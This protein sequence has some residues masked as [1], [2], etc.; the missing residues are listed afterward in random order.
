MRNISRISAPAGS[1][2]A[3]AALALALLVGASPARAATLS[4]SELIE[5]DLVITEVMADPSKVDDSRG[6]YFEIYNAAGDDVDLNGLELSDDGVDTYTISSSVVV[7]AGEKIVLG[8]NSD[9]TL[10]GGIPVVDAVYTRSKFRFDNAAD[11]IYL[12]YG[13]T[14][15]DSFKWG[16]TTGF[17]ASTSGVAFNLDVGHIDGEKNDRAYYWCDAS[18]PYGSGDLGTPGDDNDDC[19]ITAAGVSEL[20]RGDL[21]LTEV[22]IDPTKVDD[23]VGEWFEIYN[24]SGMEVNLYGLVL[25]D[26]G[27]DVYTLASDFIAEPGDYVL[28][29]VKSSTSVNGGL[30]TVD[31]TWVRSTFRFDNPADEIVINSG[32]EDLDEMSWTRST[33]LTSGS[34]WSL[35]PESM[36][37]DANDSSSA[38]CAGATSYGLGDLGTPGSANDDC[39]EDLDG[40]GYAGAE[41]CDDG[42]A[43]INPGATETCNDLDDN[44]DDLVD[45]DPS[46]ATLW[47]LDYDGDTYGGRKIQ[48]T[49][50]ENPNE[51]WYVDNEDDCNDKDEGSYPGASEVCDDRD[52]DCDEEVDEEAADM[53]TF[54]ADADAD[55]Y[56]D[57]ASSTSACEAPTGYAANDD[58]CDDTL[59]T[60]SPDGE[61]TCNDLDDDCNGRTDDYASD[62]STWYLDYDEDGYGATKITV[63]A[64]DAPTYFTADSSDCDDLDALVSPAAEEVCEDGVDNNCDDSALDCSVTGDTDLADADAKFTGDATTTD[65][66]RGLHGVGDLNGDGYGDIGIGAPSTALESAGTSPG[67]A[68]V[69]YGPST[70]TTA[71]ST[72]ADA[73]L[74]GEVNGDQAGYA[75]HAAGDQDGD[76]LDDLLVGARDEATG[77]TG[78]GAYYLLS[79]PVTG[80]LGLGSADAK[81][82]GE[83]AT[84]VAGFVL[85]GAG[86][87]DGDGTPDVVT[88]AYGN[89]SAASE[90]GATYIS[91]GPITG[92]AS[93]SAADVILYGEAADDRSGRWVASEGDVDADGLADLMVG[94]YLSDG[95]GSL[96]DAGRAYL[97]YGTPTGTVNLS[98]ADAILTGETAGDQAGYTVEDHGDVDGDGYDDVLVSAVYENSIGSRNGA[99][100]LLYGPITGS[101]NLS[102]ADVKFTGVAAGDHSGVRATMVSDANGDGRDE[103]LIG[104][105]GDDT[106]GSLAG[107]SYIIYGAPSG[108]ISLS[109]ADGRFLGEAANDK[110]GTTVAEAGDVDGDGLGDVLIGAISE[111]TG[112]TNAGAAYLILGTGW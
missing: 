98:D 71:L 41:D 51:L 30:P 39:P 50:C 67:A 38:W 59:A 33:G 21:L 23:A 60:V 87:I 70:G 10:N 17:G 7:A 42:D 63:Q 88:G 47:S 19:G 2:S 1:N 49:A 83:A 22:L 109:A 62:A 89:S 111:P 74:S 95:D 52:N 112:G 9:S 15:I 25:K 101:A 68:Y 78:A 108:S 80:A 72:G 14:V 43:S 53:G 54:Y 36:D 24:A 85:S 16:A 65:A 76:G 40:D 92:T 35:D 110:A 73:V 105:Y 94:A 100:Y 75:V 97:V 82:T 81:R 18:T 27:T 91:Y 11:E 61:E 44:C 103:V 56:G 102:A 99:T 86:D 34:S 104:A 79:G 57:A 96:A 64:C 46:D 84:N 69:V 5:G 48:V 6:E 13:S 3:R 66:S 32:T 93:L 28:L 12:S 55:G 20:T 8:V 26:K 37:A 90:A 58:D 106:G 77:G 29:A 31:M 107:A 4:V 45:N